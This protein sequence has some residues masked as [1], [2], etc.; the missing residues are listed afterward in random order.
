[1]EQINPAQAQR[2]WSRVRGPEPE[3]DTLARLLALEAEC[4]QICHY[5][6]RNTPLRDSRGLGR[7]TEESR[8]FFHILNGMAL[9]AEEDVTVVAPPSVRGNG[10]GL[11]RQC[12][13]T[14]RRA[15]A[16]VETLSP[17]RFPESKPLSGEM[18][19]SCLTILELLGQLPRK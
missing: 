1:M 4:R 12:L 13:T 7:M 19:R 8:R 15:I 14:R 5:L 3:G 11:L 6:H 10:I 18:E 2:V 17:E 16:L 9:A